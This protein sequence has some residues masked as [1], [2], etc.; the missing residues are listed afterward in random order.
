MVCC[1]MEGSVFKVQLPQALRLI[2]HHLLCFKLKSPTTTVR[3]ELFE[4]ISSKIKV[5][6]KVSKFTQNIYFKVN[7]FIQAISNMQ[8]QK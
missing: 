7:A 8:F 4:A 2:S 1:S 3:K 5:T 6:D